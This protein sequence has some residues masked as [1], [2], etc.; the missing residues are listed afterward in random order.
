MRARG[1]G[2][3]LLA[4]SLKSARL[5]VSP[6][7]QQTLLWRVRRL[8]IVCFINRSV[9]FIQTTLKSGFGRGRENGRSQKATG[10]SMLQN[11]TCSLI[12]YFLVLY[13]PHILP[14]HI[15]SSLLFLS[16]PLLSYAL[17]SIPPTASLLSFP[18]PISHLLS[19]P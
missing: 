1:S 12:R 10:M 3:L 8:V 9:C 18:P 5:R 7:W 19:S 2:E 15:S 13:C 14:P 4:L 6:L 17:N 16:F 11:V